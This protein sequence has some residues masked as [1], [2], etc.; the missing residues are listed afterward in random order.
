MGFKKF[1][2]EWLVEDKNDETIYITYTYTLHSGNI[3]IF[4][5]HWMFTKLIW[6]KYMKHAME[7]I[8]LLA[9]SDSPYIYK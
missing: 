8:K 6:N 1:T 9:D 2:G 5:F 3:L 4:P 7:N